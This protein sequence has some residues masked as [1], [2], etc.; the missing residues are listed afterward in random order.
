MGNNGCKTEKAIEICYAFGKN[1]NLKFKITKTRS[2]DVPA[3]VENGYAIE[4][5]Q[6]KCF[7]REWVGSERDNPR[8]HRGW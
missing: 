2:K 4:F 7:H 3:P 5:P 6:A 1:G 8:V